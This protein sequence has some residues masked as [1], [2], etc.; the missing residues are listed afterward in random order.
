LSGSNIPP[1]KDA[2]VVR[3]MKLNIPKNENEAPETEWIDIKSVG[4]GE[5][6]TLSVD[7][8]HLGEKAICFFNDEANKALSLFHVSEYEGQTLG[9]RSMIA[10]GQALDMT[11]KKVDVEQMINQ[12]N[13]LET[14]SM[15]ISNTEFEKDGETRTYKRITFKV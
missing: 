8:V 9:E 11:G 5:S 6:I 7:R 10:L 2:G 4:V 13:D 14:L 1:T 12:A 15:K 3:K